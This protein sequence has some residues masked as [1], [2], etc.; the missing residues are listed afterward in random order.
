MRV[1]LQRM[2]LKETALDELLTAQQVAEYLGASIDTLA[3]DRYNHRGLPYIRIGRRI[4]YR[5]KDV[6][7]YLDANTVSR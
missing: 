1:Y 6:A 3:V 5:A 2:A 7:E 4:R